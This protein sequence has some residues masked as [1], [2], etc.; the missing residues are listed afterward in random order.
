MTHARNTAAIAG[1]AAAKSAAACGRVRAA[2][3]AW[4][5]RDGAVTVA[6][7]CRAAR[8]SKAF[9]YDPQHA[10]LLRELR[11]LAAAGP[12]R[13][14][15]AVARRGKSDAAKDAQLA[16]LRERVV[17]LERQVRALQQENELLYG[18]LA[19]RPPEG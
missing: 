6:A 17:A 11:Q 16:R 14:S 2:L 10:D 18:R 1:L 19:A 13:A 7:V 3:A 8:V 15:L 4:Q 9:L 12:P 5:E